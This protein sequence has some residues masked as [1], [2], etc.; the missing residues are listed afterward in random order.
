VSITDEL[1]RHLGT[2]RTPELPEDTGKLGW[3]KHF[4]CLF[5][6][7]DGKKTAAINYGI[8]Y[9]KCFRCKHDVSAGT[10]RDRVLIGDE[11]VDCIVPAGT[12]P[13]FRFRAQIAQAAR[14]INDKLPDY[15]PH[16][17]ALSYARLRVLV[18]AGEPDIKDADAGKLPVWEDRAQFDFN[19]VDRFVLAALNADLMDWA[20]KRARQVRREGEPV[21]LW[22][23]ALQFL[24]PDLQYDG[25]AFQLNGLRMPSQQG[26]LTLIRFC[27]P[28]IKTGSPGLMWPG[29]LVSRLP[30]SIGGYGKSGSVMSWGFKKYS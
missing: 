1:C 16:D 15:A 21:P 12:G 20:D 28:S 14:T 13:V 5:C 29:C 9:Y 10:Y 19:E 7:A 6:G 27:V 2:Y 11:C 3:S 4:P 26:T 23:A 24:S 17:D 25:E 8:G 18:Y 22:D 30:L